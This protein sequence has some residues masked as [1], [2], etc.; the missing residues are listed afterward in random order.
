MFL[1]TVNI[2]INGKYLLL[3]VNNFI[4]GKWYLLTV[5]YKDDIAEYTYDHSFLNFLRCI[6]QSSRIKQTWKFSFLEKTEM[7]S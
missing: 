6:S 5:H 1:L 4:N 2:S 7:G 3:T